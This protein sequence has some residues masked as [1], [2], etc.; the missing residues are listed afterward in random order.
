MITVWN[1]YFQGQSFLFAHRF[2]KKKT[3]RLIL[4]KQMNLLRYWDW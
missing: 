2:K 1:Y 4:D 3:E